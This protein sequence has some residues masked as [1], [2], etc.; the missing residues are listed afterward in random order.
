MKILV[1][2]AG[3][4]GAQRIQALTKLSP[5]SEIVVFDPKVPAGTKLSAKAKAVNELSAFANPYDAAVV[6]TPHDTAVELLPKVFPVAPFVLV[7][8]PLGR[9]GAE[10][11]S[12]IAVA[13]K[14]GSRIFVGLNY[15]FLKNVQQLHNLLSSGEF[16]KVLGVDGVLAHGAQPGYDKSWKT[17]GVRCGGGVCI[18]PGI[19]LFDLLQWLF[20]G[21][22]L[23]AGHLSR[24][25]WPI[26]VE[27][28]ASLALTLPGGAVANLYLTLSSWQ[29]RMELTVETEKAQFLL[30][31]R[32]K[33]YGSQRLTIVAKWP[34]LQ[35]GE[36][37][38]TQ[39]DYGTE[40]ASLQ[41]ET[42]NFIA[43]CTGTKSPLTIA[44]AE[45][46]LCSMRIVDACYTKLPKTY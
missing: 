31:G 29:S 37:R 27:D 16:G 21:A 6:A 15:R 3:L 9:T 2:G 35:P 46:A 45:D 42:E 8:K 25:F 30:R 12:L 32:G 20:G 11:E 22:D 26:Q 10:A 38:E 13:K 1:A 43:A 4:I 18:D 19:H 5:V 14:S 44:T 28:H 36:P 24:Q 41:L 33:F 23:A 39:F 17:D 34:W 7:E 40:D